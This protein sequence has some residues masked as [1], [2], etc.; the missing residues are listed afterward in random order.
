M[1]RAARILAFSGSLRRDSF[2]QKLARIAADAAR[3]AGATVTV[4][5]LR[6]VPMPLFSEDLEQSEGLPAGARKLKELMLAHEGLLIA[7]PEYN[8]SISAA[9]KN[10]IDWASRAAPGE[11]PLACFVDKVAGLMAT[12]PGTLGGLR[13]LVTLRM[14]L[15]NINVLVLPN[16]L[17]VPRAHEAF[18]DDGRLKDAKQ[19]AAIEKLAAKLTSVI[20]RLNAER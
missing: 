10:A 7:S 1:T 19:Q 4:L 15:S 8:S 6:D 5:D 3:A 18:G 9:L 17:T 12:S 16:Q 2:N 11:P 14:I 13:G 20:A